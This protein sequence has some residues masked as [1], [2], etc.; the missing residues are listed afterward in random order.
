MVK[1]D[2]DDAF[3]GP[4]G[5]LSLRELFDGRRQLIL[6]HFMFGPGVEGWPLPAVTAAR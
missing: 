3:E 4:R 2:K 5:S 6:Y 1:I